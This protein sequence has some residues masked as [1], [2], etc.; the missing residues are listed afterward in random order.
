MAEVVLNAEVR[1]G[2]GNGAARRLRVEGKVPGIL[3]GGGIEPVSLAVDARALIHTLSTEAGSNVLIDL[4]VDGSKHLTLARALDRDPIRGTI[5]HVDFLQVDRN[6]EITVDIPLHFDGTAVGV[7][8]G[9]VLEHHLW[10]LHVSCK[11]G[12]VPANITI[13]VGPL[14]IGDSVHVSDVAAPEGVTILSPMDEIIVACVVPQAM[15]EEP[16][17]VEVAIEGAV[18]PAAP[19]AE[20]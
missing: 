8:E 1:S 15:E 20:S 12:N 6:I 4:H 14:A 18:E 9:G 16:V 2:R 13:D 11:P 17:A 7:K 3:Y 10:Q 5:K 19:P